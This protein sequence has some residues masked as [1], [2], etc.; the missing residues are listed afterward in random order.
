[1]KLSLY[2]TIDI[3][4]YEIA[5][6]ISSHP[7]F[8]YYSLQEDAM[9]NI[10]FKDSVSEFVINQY[11][12][13]WSPIEHNLIIRQRFNISKPYELFG[14][15]GVTNEG[16]TLGVACHIFS[17]TSNFQK[18]IHIS[19]IINSSK[20]IEIDFEYEFKPNT[21]GGAIFVEYYI[22]L[23]ELKIKEPFKAEI[24][25]TNLMDTPLLE[26]SIICDGSGSE[27]PIEEI[28][29]PTQPLWRVELNWTDIYE[30]LFNNTSVRLILN[31]AHP[32]FKQLMN[33]RNRIN[34]YL[35]NDIIINAIAMIIQQAVLIEH[36]EF[37]EDMDYQP[38][39]IAQVIWYWMSIYEI[40]LESVDTISNSIRRHADT[41]IGGE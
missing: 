10:D 15:D 22:Y 34:Q 2:K 5:G 32:I 29:D 16:N 17:K 7:E 14:D 41:F 18:T 9:V 12:S 33:Q 19:E 24:I 13:E 8:L 38:G 37:N 20:P 23:K 39:T 27:F 1:M 28:N 4:L 3:D 6:I 25:G 30:D 21:I 35:M 11:D 36:N 40:N 31:Q 26:F